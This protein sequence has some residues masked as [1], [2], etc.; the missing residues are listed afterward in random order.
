MGKLAMF[1]AVAITFCGLLV[2]MVA[3]YLMLNSVPK[4]Y[5]VFMVAISFAVVL[6]G[7]DIGRHNL[8]KGNRQ[9]VVMDLRSVRLLEEGRLRRHIVFGK[10]VLVGATFNTAFHVPEKRRRPVP[11]T[12]EAPEAPDGKG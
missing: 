4:V 8:P 12:D 9:S 7:V 6:V 1:I 2:I 5:H 11:K 3:V 10:G